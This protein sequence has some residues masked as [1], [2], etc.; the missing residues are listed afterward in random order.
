MKES[1]ELKEFITRGGLSPEEAWSPDENV[2]LIGTDPTEWI[3]GREK[4]ITFMNDLAER[5][6]P[7]GATRLPPKRVRAFREG[8]IGWSRSDMSWQLEDGNH[9]PGRLTAVY[10]KE[11]DAWK[12]LQAHVSIGIPDEEVFG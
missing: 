10:R 11:G 7:G 2:L 5:G 3:E 6:A 12:I 1:A 4:V 9:I 8:N